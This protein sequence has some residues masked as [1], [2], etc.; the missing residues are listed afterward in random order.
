MRNPL[1]TLLAAILPAFV[2]A[3]AASWLLAEQERSLS[4]EAVL[5]DAT[6]AKASP[7]IVIV[8]NSKSRSDVDGGALKKALGYDKNVSTLLVA[9]SSAPAWYAML[10]HRVFGNGHK[11]ELVIVYG[12]LSALLRSEV[13]TAGERAGVEGQMSG[14]SAVLAEKVLGAGASIGRARRNA[15]AAHDALLSGVRDV[16]VGL[17]AAPPSPDG[18]MAAGAATAG[19]ALEKMFGSNAK[20]RTTGAAQVMPVAAAERTSHAMSA[21]AAPVEASLVPDLI[22][23]AEKNGARILFVRAPMPAGT[24]YL[25]TLSPETESAVFTLIN[26]RKAS[27]IDLQNTPLP[28]GAWRDHLHLAQPG[29][30]VLTDALIAAMKASNILDGGVAAARPVLLPERIARVGAG[31]TLPTPRFVPTPN[32]ACGVQ[33]G[34]PDLAFL[35]DDALNGAGFGKSSPLT[36]TD[37]AGGPLTPRSPAKD[38]GAACIGEWQHR[39]FGAVVAPRVAGGDGLGIALTEATSV[40]DHRGNPVWW[41]Y[42]GTATEWAYAE[43]WGEPTLTVRITA[44]AAK[45]AGATLRVGDTEVP[46]QAAGRV[47]TAT[48]ERPAIPGP[49]AVSVAADAD[50]WLVIDELV[51]GDQRLVGEPPVTLTPLT[52]QRDPGAEPPPVKLGAVGSDGALTT[53]AVPG[54]AHIDD[55]TLRARV[56]FPCSPLQVAA[57]SAPDTWLT[58]GHLTDK[59]LRQPSRRGFG[60]FGDTLLLAPPGD[61][62]PAGPYRVRL[63]P[64]RKCN[65]AAWLYPEEEATWKVVASS[66]RLRLGA[67]LLVLDGIALL[68]E[69]DPRES[70]PVRVRVRMADPKRPQAVEGELVFP[71]TGGYG[72]ACLAFPEPFPPSVRL[73]MT[74]T[75][76]D[77]NAWFVLHNARIGESEH[78]QGCDE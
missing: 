18:V 24:R 63:D 4:P 11:P 13:A 9:G 73:E 1:P 65:T 25:D 20:F 68:P 44:R 70:A 74:V 52:R 67:D 72:R 57:E 58:E 16:A 38:L 50:T 6:L 37:A 59:M 60:H 7:G 34:L 30:V 78:L 10:E 54:L 22:D 23:L 5:N 14:E 51:L 17:F 40:T 27:Y 32:R 61:T 42:P 62:M 47:L 55:A 75:S 45:G 43:P 76:P 36:V 19:P 46:L 15:T 31:P 26:Q 66:D 48:L 39:K 71:A 77:A 35:S 49:W 3:A 56:E 41:V 33:A 69:G 8:G 53:L 2:L 64:K 21:S 28:G 12:Q 29:R